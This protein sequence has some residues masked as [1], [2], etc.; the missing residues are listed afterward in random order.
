PDLLDD[1]LAAVSVRYDEG[2]RW[3]VLERGAITVACNLGPKPAEVPLDDARRASVLLTSAHEP[4]AEGDAI[5][6]PAESVTIYST[7]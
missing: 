4:G 5:R 3:L 6:L 7:R 2:A 1:D